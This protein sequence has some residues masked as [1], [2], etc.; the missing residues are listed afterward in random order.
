[1]AQSQV[2]NEDDNLNVEDIV[3]EMDSTN[4]VNHLLEKE[5]KAA[6]EEQKLAKLASKTI[7]K[8]LFPKSNDISKATP[9]QLPPN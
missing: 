1:M 4:F 2:S 7:T 3:L 6:G 8:S 5:M 9:K